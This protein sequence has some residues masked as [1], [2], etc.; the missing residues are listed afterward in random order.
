MGE[1][2]GGEEKGFSPS[3]PSALFLFRFHLSPFPQKRLILRLTA[4]QLDP[5]KRRSLGMR[6]RCPVSSTRPRLSEPPFVFP[7]ILFCLFRLPTNWVCCSL[8]WGSAI[9]MAMIPVA[10][11]SGKRKEIYKYDAPWTIY[12]MNWSVR[13]DKRFRLALGSFVEEYNNKVWYTTNLCLFYK[14]YFHLIGSFQLSLSLGS[15][16]LSR[17]GHRRLCGESDFWPSI[18]NNK[19]YLDSWQCKSIELLFW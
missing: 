13:P 2:G 5:M 9:V 6:L 10:G 14:L 11:A 18:P 16:Y 3:G 12:G 4:N 1:G 15:D 8:P 7:W 19:N 17:R